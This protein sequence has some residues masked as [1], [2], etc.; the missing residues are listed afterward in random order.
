MFI[1]D[2]GNLHH[3][4]C[5]WMGVACFVET[6]RI[7]M[8]V[9]WKNA[10]PMS[11]RLFWFFQLLFITMWVSAFVLVGAEH[12]VDYVMERLND[13]GRVALY[14]HFII[15]TAPTLVLVLANGWVRSTLDTDQS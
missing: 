6:K 14:F 1:V 2:V 9:L 4:P 10:S 7:K 3:R 15:P 13:I 12:G 11:K 8:K 5:D